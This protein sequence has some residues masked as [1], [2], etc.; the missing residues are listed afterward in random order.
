MCAITEITIDGFF[1]CPSPQLT[2]GDSAAKVAAVAVYASDPMTKLGATSIL[3]ADER[4]T[5]V[6][7]DDFVLA[8]V[9][10]V[11]E[12]F[13]GYDIFAFLRE[14]RA[15]S[16]RESP[17]RCVIVTERTL[18]D[19]LLTAI[20]CGMAAMLPLDD[21]E[22]AE[23]VR[24]TLAVSQGG[25]L[26]SPRLQGWLLNRLERVRQDV[27]EPHGL[28]LSGPSERERDVLR[29]LADGYGTDEIATEL[30][31]S[32]GTVKNVL[33]GLMT[34]YGLHS[35]AHAVAFALRTAVI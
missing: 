6:A 24:T 14:V 23:L 25:A 35:R 17:P 32:A 4:L 28:T 33:H 11:L 9:I 31:Y 26:L 20:E 12:E 30:S 18:P 1:P 2:A 16:R 7:E 27:L 8:D 13:L 19:A 22:G 21:T 29:L 5:V 15:S 10:V 3:G 34:R